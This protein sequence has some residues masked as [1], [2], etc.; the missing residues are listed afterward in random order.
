[1]LG[2][3][4]NDDEEK[5]GLLMMNKLKKFIDDF[6]FIYYGIYSTEL[7]HHYKLLKKL[8]N[9]RLPFYHINQKEKCLSRMQDNTKNLQLF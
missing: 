6:E 5:E 1:M 8:W 4:T 7:Y 2:Q 9:E 3:I